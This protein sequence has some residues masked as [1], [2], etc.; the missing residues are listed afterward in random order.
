MAI[1]HHCWLECWSTICPLITAG[2][3]FWVNLIFSF[4]T[5]RIAWT[6]SRC[7]QVDQT[8]VCLLSWSAEPTG[9]YHGKES[10]ACQ[11]QFFTSLRPG[12][13]SL[14]GKALPDKCIKASLYIGVDAWFHQRP[15]PFLIFSYFV[16]KLKGKCG[17]FEDAD[18]RKRIWL[19]VEPSSERTSSWERYC[20]GNPF[21]SVTYRHKLMSWISRVVNRQ[22]YCLVCVILRDSWSVFGLKV[23]RDNSVRLSIRQSHSWFIM[24]PHC[25]QRLVRLDWK[26]HLFR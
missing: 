25:Q 6:E 22:F 17:S 7:F 14:P 18:G 2:T 24:N 16:W 13:H 11:Y 9:V 19:L 10:G 21:T 23:Y 8:L 3:L 15:V 20:Q 1:S 26:A 5:H 4:I 12:N